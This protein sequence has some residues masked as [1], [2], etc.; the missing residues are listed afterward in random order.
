MDIYSNSLISYTF[1]YIDY[2]LF[3]KKLLA[4]LFVCLN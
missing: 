2:K 4:Y 1:Y 3:N